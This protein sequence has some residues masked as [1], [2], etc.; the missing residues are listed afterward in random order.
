MTPVQKLAREL[1]VASYSDA[2][3][4]TSCMDEEAKQKYLEAAKKEAMACMTLAGAVIH[5]FEDSTQ[6]FL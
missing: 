5:V 4:L 1:F 6:V 3:S 2:R